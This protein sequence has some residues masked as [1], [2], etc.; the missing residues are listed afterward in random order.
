MAEKFERS[1]PHI[2]VGTIGHVDHGKT[3][4][5]ASILKVLTAHGMKASQKSVD[6]IDAAVDGY[7]EQAL[8]LDLDAAEGDIGHLQAGATQDPL[9]Q[10]GFLPFR[11]PGFTLA[12][13]TDAQGS[14]SGVFQEGATAD[15]G[16][17][18]GSHVVLQGMMRMR[19]C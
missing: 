9:L 14:G 19:I 16:V 3:T 7:V 1:K 11:S 4:L 5:T 6:Q 2:N 17:A 8:L 10:G 15:L 13:E 12:E 18:R